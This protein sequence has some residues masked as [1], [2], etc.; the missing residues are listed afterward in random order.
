MLCSQ[1]SSSSNCSGLGDLLVLAG[2]VP[3]SK[4]DSVPESEFVIDDSEIVLD[5]VFG[6]SDLVSNFL[7]LESLGNKLNNSA[8]SFVGD[9]LSVTF[10]SKHNCLRY[11]S[12]A[13][14]TR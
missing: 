3:E 1:A 10:A 13:S 7:V 4:L 5:D 2:F 11:K 9:A 8:L 6:S 14:F 12:V